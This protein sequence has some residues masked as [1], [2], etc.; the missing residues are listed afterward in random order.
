MEKALN[1]PVA[2]CFLL[3]ERGRN[4]AGD[5]EVVHDRMPPSLLRKVPLL[6]FRSLL[7]HFEVEEGVEGGNEGERVESHGQRVVWGRGLY[8]FAADSETVTN[9]SDEDVYAAGTGVKVLGLL[10][11]VDDSL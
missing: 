10:Q 9:M 2:E 3:D 5:E 4:S 7:A 6:V 11:S 8:S 1:E